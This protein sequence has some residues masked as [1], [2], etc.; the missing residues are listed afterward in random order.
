[1]VKTPKSWSSRVKSLPRIGH[2]E[3]P[4]CSFFGSNGSLRTYTLATATMS[5]SKSA[6]S[7]HAAH[8]SHSVTRG[9]HLACPARLLRPA[10]T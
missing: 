10:G 3:M 4:S 1:M 7:G 6:T 2:H 9:R 8:T 5:R